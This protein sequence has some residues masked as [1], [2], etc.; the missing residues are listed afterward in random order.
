MIPSRACA[1][2]RDNLLS[3]IDAVCNSSNAYQLAIYKG[4]G[5]TYGAVATKHFLDQRHCFHRRALQFQHQLN[6][7][8]H[9]R[10]VAQSYPPLRDGQPS[11]ALALAD[12]ERRAD[13]QR[14]RP[15]HLARRYRRNHQETWMS[16]A[17]AQSGRTSHRC[18]NGRRDQYRRHQC[19]PLLALNGS[20]GFTLQTSSQPDNSANWT[21]VTPSWCKE[22]TTQRQSSRQTGSNSS[23]WKNE[24]TRSNFFWS[25]CFLTLACCQNIAAEEPAAAAHAIS[26]SYHGSCALIWFG[27]QAQRR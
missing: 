13:H 17:S 2:Y 15:V 18:V 10:P 25:C 1:R 24:I 8:R 22:Q 19:R 7:R 11:P 23:D 20:A 21:L 5:T 16:Y 6:D 14:P 3:K 26:K 4:S 9:L 12:R 27:R